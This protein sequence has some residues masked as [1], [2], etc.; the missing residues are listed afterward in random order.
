MKL[1]LRWLENP[2]MLPRMWKVFVGILVILVAVDVIFVT[3][4]H[5]SLIF[6]TIPGFSAVYGFVACTA[7]VVIA[8]ILRKI[9]KRD[10]TYYE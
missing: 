7:L 6:E 5:A 4:E 3:H 8:K 1:S 9:C 2:G 10:M